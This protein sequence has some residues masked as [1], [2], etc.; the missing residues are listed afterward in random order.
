[1]QISLYHIVNAYQA[2]KIHIYLANVKNLMIS[3]H[4]GHVSSGCSL[5]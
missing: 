5:A 2:L 3:R 1:M 4:L